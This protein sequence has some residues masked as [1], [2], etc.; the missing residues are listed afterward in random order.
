MPPGA[1]AVRRALFLLVSGTLP[2]AIAKSAATSPSPG[3]EGHPGPTSP[4]GMDALK[5]SWYALRRR[6][7]HALQALAT[8]ACFK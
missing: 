4:T 8:R 3:H 2:L 6:A 7:A 5:S 1:G